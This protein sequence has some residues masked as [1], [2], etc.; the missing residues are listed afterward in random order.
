MLSNTHYALPKHTVAS[1]L[2]LVTSPLVI[3][4][5]IGIN[6]V[7]ALGLKSVPLIVVIGQPFIIKRGDTRKLA[8]T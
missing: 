6:A 2:D 1:T 4:G 7:K 8:G 5:N 3:N